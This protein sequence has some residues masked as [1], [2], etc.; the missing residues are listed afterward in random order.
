MLDILMIGFVMQLDYFLRK[1]E[2]DDSCF[3][4]VLMPASDVWLL[5]NSF[6]I[7]RAR[8]QCPSAKC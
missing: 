1:L 7:M 4:W 5:A 3:V 6:T 2:L 8:V